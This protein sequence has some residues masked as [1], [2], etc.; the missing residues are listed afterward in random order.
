MTTIDLKIALTVKVP[1]AKGVEHRYELKQGFNDVPKEVAEHWYVKKY[2]QPVRRVP[3]VVLP[4][5]ARP[6]FLA[7]RAVKAMA[8][9]LKAPAPA[10]NAAPVPPPAAEQPAEKA[11]K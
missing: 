5:S 9:G 7:K 11:Q 3:R 4:T 2:L 8:S 1:D 6:G 10:A